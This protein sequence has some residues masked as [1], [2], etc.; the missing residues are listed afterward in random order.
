[1]ENPPAEKVPGLLGRIAEAPDGARLEELLEQINVSSTYGISAAGRAD[2]LMAA[3]ERAIHL[4]E[5]GLS[6]DCAAR[7]A[8]LYDEVGDEAQAVNAQLLTARSH[9]LR[10]SVTT[11]M[12]LASNLLDKARSLGDKS[13][14][15]IALLTMGNCHWRMEKTMEARQDLQQADEL[16]AA[17]G[18]GSNLAVTRLALGTVEMLENRFAEG[19]RL[20]QQAL[21][22]F[23]DTGDEDKISRT[24]NNL[25]GAA[26]HQRDW[27]KARKYLE[28]SL[29]RHSGHRAAPIVRNLYYNLGLISAREHKTAE[30]RKHLNRSLRL[31]Q[32]AGD[33]DVEASSLLHLGVASLLDG[34]V[35][36]ARNYCKLAG[37]RAEGQITFTRMPVN[38]LGAVI[39]LASGELDQAREMWQPLGGLG[40]ELVEECHN[41]I[42]WLLESRLLEKTANAKEAM[43]QAHRWKGSIAEELQNLGS[44]P[45]SNT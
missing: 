9:T 42:C 26:F 33:V 39:M 40:D 18:D 34:N 23:I 14:E 6:E 24:L 45:A 21:Q 41:L 20:F 36:E 11:G 10:N 4:G 31:A 13:L 27:A 1:M 19:E 3:G 22:F 16:F 32:L 30:A 25:A 37:Q 8:D 17:L 43:D 29:A 12:H 35:E 38:M 7:A 2:V 15:A 44:N 28:E 5:F